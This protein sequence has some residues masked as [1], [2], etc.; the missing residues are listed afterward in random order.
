LSKKSLNS[1]IRN[2]GFI[3]QIIAK[4]TQIKERVGVL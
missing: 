4:T 2:N 1:K 3:R